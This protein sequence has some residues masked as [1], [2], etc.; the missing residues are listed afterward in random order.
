GEWDAEGGTVALRHLQKLAVQLPHKSW[1]VLCLLLE[2]LAQVAALSNVNETTSELLSQTFAPLLCRP[3]GSAFMSLR[4]VQDLLKIQAV[5][6]VLIENHTILSQNR[7]ASNHASAGSKA[8]VTGQ[9]KG[10]GKEGLAL[11]LSAG[12]RRPSSNDLYIVQQLMNDSVSLLVY[13]GSEG[14]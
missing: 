1:E 2:F 12:G 14:E 10:G 4:H 3:Q 7:N 6:R 5:V 11:T 13:A 9:A 8:L